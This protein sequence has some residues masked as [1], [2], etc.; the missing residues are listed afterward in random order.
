MRRE[1]RIGRWLRHPGIVHVRAAGHHAGRTYLLMD[2]VDGLSLS[3]LQRRI[4]PLDLPVA[5]R[6][7]HD[8]AVAVGAAH[9]ARGPAGPLRLI[10]R[11]LKPANMMLDRQ[12]RVRLLDFGIAAS[13]HWTAAERLSGTPGYMSLET[14]MGDPED[15]RVDVFGLGATLV[16]LVLGRP[17]WPRFPLTE[18]P[19]ESCPRRVSTMSPSCS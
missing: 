6:I 8:A 15:A 9:R 4:G 5:A 13:A 3:E 10:H 2:L 16:S 7:V 1:A 18:P 11:D 12:G 17:P 19:P 14:L